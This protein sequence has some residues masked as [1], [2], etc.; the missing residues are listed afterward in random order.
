MKTNQRQ[1]LNLFKRSCKFDLSIIDGQVKLSPTDCTKMAAY[2]I[3]ENL[4]PKTAYFKKILERQGYT[5]HF[6]TE[7]Q[8][9]PDQNYLTESVVAI[10]KDWKKIISNE[11][12]PKV[13]SAWEE[14]NNTKKPVYRGNEYDGQKNNTNYQSWVWT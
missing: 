4:M 3:M 2:S 6:E 12:Y 14:K 5:T 9:K 1:V 7:L 13:L 8:A 10:E 11:T